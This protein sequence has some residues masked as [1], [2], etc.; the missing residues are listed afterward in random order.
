MKLFP[1]PRLSAA[2]AVLATA[3]LALTA[4]GGADDP[5]TEGGASASTLS[6][7]GFSVAETAVDSLY[8]KFTDTDA[9]KDTK[10]AKS[11][12]ASGD[13]SR[14]VEAG[15]KADVVDFS[16]PGDVKRLVKAGLVAQ[17][18]NTGANKGVVSRSVVVFGVRE[19]NP[20]NIDSWDDLVKPGIEIV[21]PNPSSSGAARWNALAAYGHVI[22]DGG[23]EAEATTYTNEFFSHVVSMP[24]SG[25]DATQAFLSGTGDVFMTYE[26]EAILANQ[27]GQGFDYIVP[28]TTL[29][30]E[31]AGAVTEAAG[32]AAKPFLD[33][34]LSD[35]GQQI[36]AAKGYRP[37]RD[38]IDPGTVDGATDPSNPFPA[39]KNLITVDG[40]LG[41]WDVADEKFFSDETGLVTKAVAATGKAE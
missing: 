37:I 6:V 20:K 36:L 14:A 39:I 19:G 8:E 33:F 28:Q 32:P 22:K 41:G 5:K 13:Q 27:K 12:G 10:L 30:I 24:P 35:E 31:N 17:D 11:F 2:V 1:R 15:L 4:C 23:T 25:R 29:L 16:I 18:W 9:G 40:D 3:S 7:V 38:G 26:N 21:T 34:I